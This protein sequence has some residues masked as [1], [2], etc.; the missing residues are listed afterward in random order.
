MGAEDFAYYSQEIPACFIRVGTGSSKETR[1]GL[2]TS[3]FDIDEEAMKTS[4]KLF[5]WLATRL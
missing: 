1:N 5:S 4:I 3:N 2:H